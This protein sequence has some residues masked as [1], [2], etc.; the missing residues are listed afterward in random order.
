MSLRSV[1]SIRQLPSLFPDL[2]LD[3]ALRYINSVP[4]IP[5][6]NRA[7]QRKLEGIISSEAVLK[8]YQAHG[9]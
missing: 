9:S 3:V 8:R 5:V 1:L 6:V 4:L 2:P 7:D